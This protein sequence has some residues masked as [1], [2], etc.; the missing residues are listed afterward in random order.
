MPRKKIQEIKRPIQ[1]MKPNKLTTYTAAS[2]TI[3]SSRSFLKLEASP[4]VKNVIANKSTRN[5]VPSSLASPPAAR[6]SG[7]HTQIASSTTNVV[8]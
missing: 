5:D 7:R 3:P 2:L 1:M 6:R 8:T 4:I